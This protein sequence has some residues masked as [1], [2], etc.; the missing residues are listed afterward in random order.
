MFNYLCKYFNIINI[1]YIYEILLKHN[2]GFME[3]YFH[4]KIIFQ[5][6]LL[7]QMNLCLLFI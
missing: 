2:Y 4:L 7:L 3:Y 6:T 5:L 1:K